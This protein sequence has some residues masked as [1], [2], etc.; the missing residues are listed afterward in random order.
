MSVLEGSSG[1][2][3]RGRS[4]PT[5]ANLDRDVPHG[6]FATRT[7]LG[8]IESAIADIT[9]CINKCKCPTR[10]YHTSNY[11]LERAEL[12]L[13]SNE[14][15]ASL[16]DANKSISINAKNWP[17]YNFRSGLLVKS[18]KLQDALRDL[19]KSIQLNDNEA[20]SFINRAKLRIEM[21][22]IE[23]A[24]GD[25]SKVRDWGIDDFD[26]WLKRNCK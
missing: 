14:V 18:G 3:V 19:D 6:T 8:M 1:K 21:G 5:Q 15:S 16:A 7:Q 20:S 10:M 22:D 9:K 2:P 26:S 23:G 4:R 25:L 24:C 17:A 11:Y 12:Y 13:R